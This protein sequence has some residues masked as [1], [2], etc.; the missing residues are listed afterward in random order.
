MG[1]PIAWEIMGERVRSSDLGLS[2]GWATLRPPR[3]HKLHNIPLIALCS[4]PGWIFQALVS[5]FTDLIYALT[6]V[7]LKLPTADCVPSA[8]MHS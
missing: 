6:G 8:G 2:Q 5:D 4:E 1:Q 3:I 7:S